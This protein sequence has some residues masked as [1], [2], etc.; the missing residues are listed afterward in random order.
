MAQP[1]THEVTQ[2]LIEWSDGDKAALD[3]LMPL[4]L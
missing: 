3:E 1:S 4:T 2:L